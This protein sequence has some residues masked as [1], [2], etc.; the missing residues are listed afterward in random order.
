MI[1]SKG[2]EEGFSAISEFIRSAAI[3]TEPRTAY[4][5]FRRFEEMVERVRRFVGAVVAVEPPRLEPKK[6]G[7]ASASKVNPS[8]TKELRNIT[9]PAALNVVTIFSL[10]K[11]RFR[12]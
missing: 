4:C 5:I 1:F 7:A 10:M 12:V 3:T 2:C 9:F 11:S 6:L 8:K